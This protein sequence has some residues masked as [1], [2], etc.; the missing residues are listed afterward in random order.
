MLKP[1]TPA[2]TLV[3]LQISDS[4][5]EELC[6]LLGRE[7]GGNRKGRDTDSPALVI[8]SPTGA[9]DMASESKNSGGRESELSW[10]DRQR[11]GPRGLGG[12]VSC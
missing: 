9:V 5:G 3:D 11:W 1:Y 7:G 10:R 8:H 6:A 12:A 2:S 4:K